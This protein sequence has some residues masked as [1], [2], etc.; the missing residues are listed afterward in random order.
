M[1]SYSCGRPSTY[2]FLDLYPDPSFHWRVDCPLLHLGELERL[3]CPADTLRHVL[4]GLDL[5]DPLRTGNRSPYLPFDGAGSCHRARKVITR[6][7]TIVAPHPGFRGIPFP[8]GAY[9]QDQLLA[10][11]QTRMGVHPTT[12]FG[13]TV[14]GILSSLAPG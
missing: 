4:P 7:P 12:S 14:F 1:V 5:D 2:P 8:D 11:Q 10:S 9:H 13:A 6:S 3:E